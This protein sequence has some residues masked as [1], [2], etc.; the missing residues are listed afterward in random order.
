MQKNNKKNKQKKNKKQN[1][2]N[3]VNNNNNNNRLSNK[4]QSSP[5]CVVNR[6]KVTR[7]IHY[8]AMTP[9][10]MCVQ[11]QSLTHD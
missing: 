9:S 5:F 7:R 10:P 3:L 2:K 6:R 8:T 11:H 4:Y 1:Q